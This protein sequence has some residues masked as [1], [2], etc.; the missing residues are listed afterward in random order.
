MV[1]HSKIPFIADPSINATRYMICD[2]GGSKPWSAI[3]IGVISDGRAYVYREFPDQSMGGPWALPHVNG[4]GKSVGK[5]GP[6]QRPLG[7]G[8]IDY[9]NHFEDLEDGED[10]FERID[11]LTKSDYRYLNFIKP[12]QLL[13]FLLS[14][15]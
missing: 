14:S 10:I 1:E 9:K 6:G 7:W 12:D 8:Y 4:A 5:P 13:F 11:S 2:P 3:W 15:L